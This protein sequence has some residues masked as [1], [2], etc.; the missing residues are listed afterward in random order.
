MKS[1]LFP[2]SSRIPLCLCTDFSVCNL[3]TTGAMHSCH[4]LII[5]F[6]FTALLIKY[7]QVSQMCYQLQKLP[8]SRG[9]CERCSI[10]RIQWNQTHCLGNGEVGVWGSAQLQKTVGKIDVLNIFFNDPGREKEQIVEILGSEI[11]RVFVWAANQGLWIFLAL[12]DSG[13]LNCIVEIIRALHSRFRFIICKD[14]F[15][16][17]GKTS[18]HQSRTNDRQA[19]AIFTPA[20]ELLLSFVLQR[21]FQDFLEHSSIHPFSNIHLKFLVTQT[22]L[23]WYFASVSMLNSN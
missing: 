14:I 16:W 15:G 20:K 5:F 10:K 19:C 18:G 17:V 2:T 12:W 11:N 4:Y 7:N 21:N 6:L 8:Y 1:I 23:Y 22:S 13:V 9:C 3:K